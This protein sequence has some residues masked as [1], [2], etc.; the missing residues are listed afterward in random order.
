MCKDTPVKHAFA[1]RLN[2]LAVLVALLALLGLSEGTVTHAATMAG[3]ASSI[4]SQGM[5]DAQIEITPPI[6]SS[7]DDISIRVFGEWG[8]GCVPSSPQV[9]VVSDQIFIELLTPP[10][11]TICA[12]VI[13][14]WE[15]IVVIGQLPVG[16]YEVLVTLVREEEVIGE[17]ELTVV[18]ACTLDLTPTYDTG[19]LTV[20]V[21]LGTS[22]PATAKS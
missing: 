16:I 20:E 14:S 7:A 19:I 6:P 18:P 2:L 15:E 3:A 8:N 10:P 11:D 4:S 13:T 5:G 12:T 1:T 22:V 17:T 9:S 21:L